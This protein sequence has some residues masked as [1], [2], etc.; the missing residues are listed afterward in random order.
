MRPSSDDSIKYRRALEQLDR[1]MEITKNMTGYVSSDD[2][3][4][5]EWE[6]QKTKEDP[7]ERKEQKQIDI[8]NNIDINFMYN[9]FSPENWF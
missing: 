2:E 8:D 4:A 7:W 9:L 5:S 3:P 6:I 1:V